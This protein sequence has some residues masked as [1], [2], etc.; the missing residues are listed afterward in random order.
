MSFEFDVLMDGQW[1]R[2]NRIFAWIYDCF[3]A[4]ICFMCVLNC[5]ILYPWIDCGMDGA[6]T[7][8]LVSLLGA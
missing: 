3:F 2:V 1:V 6:I 5:C 4:C 7:H 8:S